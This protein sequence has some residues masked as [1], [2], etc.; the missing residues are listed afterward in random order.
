MTNAT[1]T[2][3]R[4]LAATIFLLL[5][6]GCYTVQPTTPTAQQRADQLAR[7]VGQASGGANWP[8]I[9]TVAFNARANT[10]T[11]SST[12]K[13]AVTVST[14]APDKDN[15]AE[16]DAF[17]AWTNDTYWLIAPMKFF[18]PGVTREHLGER[19]VAGKTYQVLG[20]SFQNVG[21]TPGDRYNVYVDPLTSLIAFWD[22]M[23]NAETSMRASWERYQHPAGLKLS[24]YHQMGP[25]TISIENLS[26][27]TTD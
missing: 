27:T 6:G 17:K 11:V 10:D 24:T 18:D 19:E 3:R 25:R 4:L 16:L 15:P 14:T 2:L 23:P 12:D 13:P 5:T 8:R 22:Y 7:S 26:I 20:L 21:M 9:H 1:P